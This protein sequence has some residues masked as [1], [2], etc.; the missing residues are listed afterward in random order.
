MVRRQSQVCTA[1]PGPLA[2]TRTCEDSILQYLSSIGM[3][4]APVIQ[5]RK[6]ISISYNVCCSHVVNLHIKS[7]GDKMATYPLILSEK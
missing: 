6:Q 5:K 1:H 2:R 3:L 4:K 7:T